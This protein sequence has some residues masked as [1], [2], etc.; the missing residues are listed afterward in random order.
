MEPV[1][2]A[3]VAN[4][5]KR[6]FLHTVSLP[7]QVKGNESFTIEAGLKNTFTQI[8]EIMTGSRYFIMSFETAPENLTLLYE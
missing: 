4:S 8:F 7:E 3:G 5:G 2:S 6:S 1:P